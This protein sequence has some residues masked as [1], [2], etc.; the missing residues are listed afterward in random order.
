MGE[1]PINAEPKPYASHPHGEP[2]SLVEVMA[3]LRGLATPIVRA[4]PLA[5][6]LREP[7]MNLEVDRYPRFEY[8]PDPA[9]GP[10]AIRKGPWTG[11]YRPRV[12]P[13]EDDLNSELG[14]LKTLRAWTLMPGRASKPLVARILELTTYA[15]AINRAIWRDATLSYF[16]GKAEPES[17]GEYIRQ[18]RRKRRAPERARFRIWWSDSTSSHHGARLPTEDETWTVLVGGNLPHV[19]QSEGVV[20]DLGLCRFH[21]WPV[22][23]NDAAHVSPCKCR[24]CM[25][26]VD[27]DLITNPDLERRIRGD[28]AIG[29]LAEVSMAAGW[30]P[31]GPL[32]SV[33]QAFPNAS[34][35]EVH[36]TTLFGRLQ[37]E[38]RV[39]EYRRWVGFRTSGKP[40]GRPPSKFDE[41]TLGWI[42]QRRQDGVSLNRIYAEYSTR[43]GSPPI[44]R[45]TFLRRLKNSHRVP[46]QNPHFPR[47]PP[48]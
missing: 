2:N 33:K 22:C 37:F 31:S 14:M 28:P 4:E 19:L 48:K 12:P 40:I 32:R 36:M 42:E 18:L 30:G 20:I 6:L 23:A 27:L 15:V 39:N 41:T 7:W 9:R 3:E 21:T 46:G 13:S 35:Y 45:S 43:P 24:Y 29:V 17:V 26:T 1:S 8:I 44:A 11:G 5:D 16:S 25:H 47:L 10:K 38:E 34:A